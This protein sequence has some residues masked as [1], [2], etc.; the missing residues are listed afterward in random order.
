MACQ[1]SHTMRPARTKQHPHVLMRGSKSLPARHDVNKPP[2]HAALASSF[3]RLQFN[4][5]EL[6]KPLCKMPLSLCKSQPCA[7]SH[8]RQSMQLPRLLIKASR[9]EV[10]KAINHGG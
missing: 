6:M 5:R 1:R 3:T 8:A 2:L 10:A 9:A 7:Q 4:A